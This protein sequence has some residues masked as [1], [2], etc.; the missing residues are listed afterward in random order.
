MILLRRIF[1]ALFLIINSLVSAETYYVST[2]GSNGTYPTR[3]TI[4]NPWRTWQYAFDNTPSGDTCYF[5]GGVYVNSTEISFD[6]NDGTYSHPTCFFNYPGEE[7][8]LDCATQ[9]NSGIGWGVQFYNR[10]NIKVKGLTIRNVFQST[11]N[12]IVA[13]F[14][15]TDGCNNIIFENCKV[16]N[17]G[18]TGFTMTNSDSTYFINCDAW[19]ICDTLTAYDPGGGGVGFSWAANSNNYAG[20]KTSYTYYYGCRGWNCS[21]Q[22][23]GGLTDGSL[24]ID[25]CWA[26]TNGFFDIPGNGMIDGMGD[27]FKWDTSSDPSR[28]P[29]VVKRLTN[30]IAF[31]NEY[32]GFDENYSIYVTNA[33]VYNNFSYRNGYN[34]PLGG[35]IKRGFTIRDRTYGINPYDHTY[36]NNISYGNPEN[37]MVG[38]TF[39]YFTNH[40]QGQSSPFTITNADFVSLDTTG[41][42][43]PRQADGSLPFTNFGKLAPGSDLIDAG[44]NVGLPYHGSAPDLGW[45]ESSSGSTTPAIPVYQNSAIEN[46]TPAVVE[47]TYNLTLANIVPGASAFAVMVNT[48]ARSVNSV[49]ISGTKVLLTLSSPVSYGDAVTVSY[50]KPTTNPLQTAT[51]GQA[52]SI[53][54]QTVTNRVASVIP[55]YQNSAIENATPAVVEMT[56]NLTLANIVPG[57]S[58]FAVM[59]NTMA[60]SV[61]S[62][63]ISGTKVLLTLSNPVAYGDVVTVSYTKPTTNP[64]QTA[65]GGQAVSISAQT[66]TNRVASVIP[67]YSDSA[68]E[69]ATPAVVEMTYNLTLANIVPGASAFAVMVNTMARSVNSV[70]ISG[71]KVLL[72]LSSPVVLW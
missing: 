19:N 66:V 5:R 48:M 70:S 4:A 45:F 1:I 61:N 24:I 8:I 23:W 9:Y 28:L 34:H 27:G 31:D 57:A 29:A 3:G 38:I 65:T 26:M 10:H 39:E 50:T 62:V 51:G 12:A 60:R 36:A 59:V 63:S 67:V 21:D 40:F 33:H 41:M 43:G 53:S 71:T 58:A 30:N 11:A 15:A 52:V 64:L 25:H 44:T 54:A 14:S 2:T 56:Y 20:S 46:A 37:D 6:G 72:T 47:M 35:T 55:V 32:V 42:R 7:P 13:A 68:I 49:S 16:H 69:N 17:I 18:M 22:A